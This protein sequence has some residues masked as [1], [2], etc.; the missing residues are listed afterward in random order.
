M[1]SALVPFS[2]V[3]LLP[4]PRSVDRVDLDVG[5]HDVER[6]DRLVPVDPLRGVPLLVLAALVQVE[7]PLPPVVVLPGK[8]CRARRGHVPRAAR[9]RCGVKVIGAHTCLRWP[10]RTSPG[11]LLAS[12][13]AVRNTPSIGG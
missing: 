10:S 3:Q 6:V 12:S 13:E 5:L 2:L 11:L 7:Q 4:L 8:T 1:V 9:D